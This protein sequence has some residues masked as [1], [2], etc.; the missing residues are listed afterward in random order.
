MEPPSGENL[1]YSDLG[2][3][4]QRLRGNVE[5]CNITFAKLGTHIGPME[6]VS[7]RT[8]KNEELQTGRLHLN[9]QSVTAFTGVGL[10]LEERPAILSRS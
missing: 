6:Y 4:I 3:V 7:A 10:S 2:K 5:D 8:T 9:C 1:K